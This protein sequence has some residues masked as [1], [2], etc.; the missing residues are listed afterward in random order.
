M[1]ES[2]DVAEED[3]IESSDVEYVMYGTVQEGTS[4]RTCYLR[5]AILIGRYGD[6]M[7]EQILLYPQ[8]ST[9][10][11]ELEAAIRFHA[12]QF[13]APSFAEM[14]RQWS[15][16]EMLLPNTVPPYAQDR[17]RCTCAD[18]LPMKNVWWR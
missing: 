6:S 3:P 13:R 1:R 15:H 18:H 14:M 4:I 5:N 7:F 10:D 17:L 16:L 8:V 11:G 12:S 2:A 9:Q